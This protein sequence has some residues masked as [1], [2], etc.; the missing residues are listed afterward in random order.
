M[1]Y[2]FIKEKK[3][4]H[5]NHHWW[6]K[7]SFNAFHKLYITSACNSMYIALARF[8]EKSFDHLKLRCSWVAR[9][10]EGLFL[11]RGKFCFGSEQ[12]L[13]FCLAREISRAVFMSSQDIKVCPSWAVTLHRRPRYHRHHPNVLVLG[14]S[15]KPF[16]VF[17]LGA[18]LTI[19]VL[20]D[21]NNNHQA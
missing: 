15:D 12:I 2:F 20:F 1:G 18:R 19:T 8:Q 7:R 21:V 5:K 6:N 14:Y 17:N 4:L 13:M 10:T 3:H 16:W 11:S 9:L